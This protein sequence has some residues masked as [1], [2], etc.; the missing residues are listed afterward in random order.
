MLLTDKYADKINGIITC[1]DRMIIQGYIPRWSYAEGM[2]GYLKAN[3]I[4]FRKDDHI[5]EII[6]KTAFANRYC[7]AAETLGLGYTWTVQ[8]IECATDIM[9]KQACDLEPLYDEIIRTAVFT[10][11]PDNIAVF[12]GQRITYN[13]KKEAGTNH[14]QRIPGTRIKHYM[15]DVSIWGI[16]LDTAFGGG[17]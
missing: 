2:T 13:C 1:N 6:Q 11:K 17:N 8:Q 4:A 9:F 5:Q 10:V 16:R 12:L 3:N 15:G 7:P 14:N